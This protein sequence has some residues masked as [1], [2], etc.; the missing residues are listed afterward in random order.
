MSALL[1]FL[2]LLV[3]HP[4]LSCFAW[5]LP[6]K[7]SCRVSRQRFLASTIVTLFT[8]SALPVLADTSLDIQ[9]L[10]VGYAQLDYLVNNF[11]KETTVCGR[12]DNPYIGLC[13]RNPT[14]VM[15]AMGFKSTKHPLFQADKTMMRL[16]SMV[17]SDKA[18][19]FIDA[20]EQ[21][22]QASE[23]AS[24]IAYVSSW[25][26]ANPGGGKDRVALYIERS[27]KN[28]SDARDALR[29]AIDML[30]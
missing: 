23:E 9:K 24:G 6:L 25:A 3:L 5:Q 21:W 10:E 4:L 1:S 28:A 16:Q 29:T 26:E 11:E 12:S 19:E 22:T 30:K 8:S 18:S 14:K 20:V 13:E 2:T 15:E 27:R 7:E 17:P